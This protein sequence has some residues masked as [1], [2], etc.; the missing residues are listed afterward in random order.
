METRPAIIG[1]QKT[2]DEVLRALKPSLAQLKPD[3]Q[4]VERFLQ[5]CRR[6]GQRNP[7]ILQC[8]VASLENALKDSAALGLDPTGLMGFGYV[9]P[10]TNKRGDKEATFIPGYH[11]L[12]DMVYRTK[13]VAGV[14]VKLVH[15]DDEWD[16]L[17]SGPDLKPLILHRP[18]FTEA[19]EYENRSDCVSGYMI[20][21]DVIDGKAVATRHHW[22]WGAEIERVRK[23][24]KQT[25]R[26]GET[27]YGTWRDHWQAMALKTVIR[28][29]VKTMPLTP[30]VS[31]DLDYALGKEDE[32]L[33][34]VDSFIDVTPGDPARP[35]EGRKAIGEQDKEG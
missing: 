19:I 13:K 20:W 29:A 6:L 12:I 17:E 9:I 18:K 33:G 32:K 14:R 22:M 7:D 1:S 3:E 15:K 16:Y 34:A 31:S 24:S 30:E 10:F 8:T 23:M 27:K 21:Q 25:D 26:S 28:A 5:L 11:G 35:E 4:S 2:F